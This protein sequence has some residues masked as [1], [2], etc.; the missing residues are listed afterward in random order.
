[1]PLKKVSYVRNLDVPS[2]PGNRNAKSSPKLGVAA[3]PHIPTKQS[4]AYGSSATPIL[5]HMLAAK[6]EMNL[7]AMADEIGQAVQTAKEREMSETVS[8]P[9]MSTRSRLRS[10]PNPFDSP[11]MSVRQPT[12]EIQLFQDLRHAT[13]ERTNSTVTPYNR[14]SY[15]TATASPEPFRMN[16]DLY[17]A[18]MT[19]MTS[20]Q[21]DSPAHSA[22][23]AL[24]NDNAS[25]VSWDVERDIHDD[26][27]KRTHSNITAP[28]RRFSGRAFQDA[29]QEES[30]DIDGFVGEAPVRANIPDRTFVEPKAS[31]ESSA[32]PQATPQTV[33]RA[34]PQTQQSEAPSDRW[35][36]WL[37][38][39][40]A[41]CVVFHVILQ[42]YDTPKQEFTGVITNNTGLD[43]L[44]KQVVK[45]G[46]QVSSISKD[47]NSLRTD[48]GKVPAPTTIYKYPE[49]GMKGQIQPDFYKTNF[50]S[51]GSGVIIDP[52]MTNPSAAPRRTW[53]QSFYL[54]GNEK[55]MH[56]QPP[57]AALTSWQEYGECWCSAP[58]K[59]GMSQ[60]GIL[61]GLRVVPEDVVVEHLP[62][63]STPRPEVAPRDMELWARYRYVGDG[64]TPYRRSLFSFIR[65]NPKNIAGQDPLASDRKMLRG[66]VMDALRLTWRGESDDKFS[67]D[68]KLGPDFYRIGKWT[69]DIDG[70]SHIQRFPVTAV[71]DSENLRVDKVVFRTNRNWGGNETCI[72][73]LRLLGKM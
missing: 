32:S 39:F 40:L 34:T 66:P 58:D 69:Y 24:A 73:R 67:D 20:I 43:I 31:S 55:H 22:M 63:T 9:S 68:S 70:N 37:F 25:V 7:K 36:T 10:S 48:I 61:L 2:S 51:I 57:Q 62:K 41:S 47:M 1:M 6:P 30:S 65:G 11:R 16:S 35:W 53:L 71:I 3:L 46:A 33:P 15:S 18:S 19:T 56:S 5:P 38:R 42:I 50:L 27:L 13:P 45:L 12:P 60:I 17:P 8:S 64:I 72:Y 49:G 52:Y 54:W 26:N 23:I 44:S 14:R 4:F 59:N 28:P 21:D 29:I